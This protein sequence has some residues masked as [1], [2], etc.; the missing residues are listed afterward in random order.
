MTISWRQILIVI[1]LTLFSLVVYMLIGLIL[2]N[3][4]DSYETKKGEYWSLTSMT[5][6]EKASYIGLNLWHLINLTAIIYVIFR[7]TKRNKKNAL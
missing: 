1:S 4:D 3:Y 6:T 5:L 2:M 7:L